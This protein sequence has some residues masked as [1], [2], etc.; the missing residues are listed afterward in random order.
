MS[1]QLSLTEDQIF[2]A[3]RSFLIAVLTPGIEVIQAQ[4]NR[5]PEPS[6]TEFVI[7]TK[8]MRERIETNKDTY[9][10]ALFTG[11]IT[12]TLLNISAVSYGQLSIGSTLLGTNILPNTTVTAFGSGS[13][14]IGTYTVNPTQTITSQKIAAG[15]LNSLQP[16]KMTIQLDIHGDFSGDNAHIISTLFR[17]DYGVQLF[18]DAGF[19]VTP[20]YCSEAKQLPF[21]NGEQQIETRWTIDVVMQ[22][23]PIVT[24]PQYF[25]DQLNF[26]NLTTTSGV[27]SVDALYPP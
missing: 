26:G 12:G 13:G 18:K 23:N 4:T 16:V 9:V 17:D 5:V 14:G 10:D 2:T 19:D 20:L 1:V 25:A 11:S 22:C 15:V 7:M 24:V 6:G 27:I 3:L 21:L 8:S